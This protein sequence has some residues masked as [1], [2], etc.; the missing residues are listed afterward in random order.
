[1][2]D[3]SEHKALINLC[4]AASCNYTNWFQPA[5]IPKIRDVHKFRNLEHFK[6]IHP[7]GLYIC[8]KC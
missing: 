3:S 5:N 6:E 8:P 1:M 2:Y 4:D 7:E